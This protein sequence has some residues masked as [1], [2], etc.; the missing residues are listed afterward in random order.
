VIPNGVD[1][2][3]FPK[4]V[5]DLGEKHLIFSGAMDILANIDAAKFLCLE[6]LPALQERY[7]EVK[8]TLVGARPTE[9]ILALGHNSAIEVTGSVNSMA[10]YLHQATVCVI[11]MRTGFGIKN[12]TLEAMAA[13]IPVVASDRGLEG[14]AIDQP[15]RALRANCV[16][17]YVQAIS[18][19]FENATLRQAIADAAHAYVTQE[20]TWEQAGERYAQVVLGD[21]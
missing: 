10:E 5:Q 11:P 2:T 21:A 15:Q 16:E 13:G 4:R 6:I 19:L 12:K 7:P 17:E 20:F 9:A 14:L 3:A 18:Q 8:V 1:F